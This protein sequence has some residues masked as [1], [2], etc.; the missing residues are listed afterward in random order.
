MTRAIGAQTARATA[1]R[2]VV[3]VDDDG[4][5]AL[6]RDGDA[7]SVYDARTLAPLGERTRF[8]STIVSACFVARARAALVVEASGDAHVLHVS[9]NGARVTA[10]VRGPFARARALGRLAALR[11]RDDAAATTVVDVESGSAWTLRT[12]VKTADDDDGATL[13]STSRCERWMAVVARDGDARECVQ[14]FRA[15]PPFDGAVS[16]RLP[17]GVDARAIAFGPG[18]D[19]I[20]VFD[21]P[22]DVGASPALRVFSTNGSARAIVRGARTPFARVGD[23]LLVS[24]FE[25]NREGL[26][27]IDEITWRV[28]RAVEHPLACETS[29]ATRCHRE[30]A[31]GKYERLPKFEMKTIA[32]DAN[33]LQR[34]GV[35]MSV[36]RC[37][38]MI[39]S[40]CASDAH[41]V[42]FLWSASASAADA[43]PL[44]IFI[45]RK[46]I[47]DLKWFADGMGARLVFLC[48]DQS[49]M[50][51]F[52]PGDETPTRLPID[53]GGAFAPRA[54]VGQGGDRAD[55]FILASAAK[56]F[57]RQPV[58]G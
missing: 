35:R 12:A 6:V 48:A 7:V 53:V 30:R 51:A 45:H 20:A 46:P 27:W 18:M 4:T 38:S 21:D 33:G 15:A 10:S 57:T 49:A 58:A 1:A 14:V 25:E 2:G 56:T 16:F 41:K 23:A 9:V 13:A 43:L 55:A 47:I 11:D 5:F 39:A 8:S 29:S 28:V 52:T 37:G 44:A 42:L 54:V 3:T 34:I 50:Y 22:C 31:D 17:A 26:A 40:T 36:S 32:C 19:E 24:T